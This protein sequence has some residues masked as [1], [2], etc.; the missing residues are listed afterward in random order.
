MLPATIVS[1]RVAVPVDVR[2]A[3]VGGGV[4]ADGAAGQDGVAGIIVQA[5][6]DGGRVAADG[7]VGQRRRAVSS[8][9]TP[10][11]CMAELPLT[12]QSV[13]VRSAVP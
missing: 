11:P 12:V 7:A 6:A 5:A 2:Q 13:R 8:L 10:P 9:Y 1:V 3:A 4:A